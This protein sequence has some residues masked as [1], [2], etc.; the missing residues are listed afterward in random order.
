MD[1]EISHLLRQIG[2]Y[3]GLPT[4]KQDFQWQPKGAKM[5]VDA[6]PGQKQPK[7]HIKANPHSTHSNRDPP[8]VRQNIHPSFQPLLPTSPM[9]STAP[10]GVPYAIPLGPS[11]LPRPPRPPRPSRQIAKKH[12]NRM[13]D[14][15]HDPQTKRMFESYLERRSKLEAIW[16]ASQELLLRDLEPPKSDSHL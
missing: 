8:K 12:N 11:G 9:A 15:K 16:T 7:I 14:V 3:D 5:T 10:S 6:S 13:S 2:G 4:S 1:A